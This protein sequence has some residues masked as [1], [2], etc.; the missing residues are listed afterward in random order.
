MNPMNY[1]QLQLRELFHLE[2]LRWFGRKVKA[3]FYALKGGANL[4]FFFQSI[5]YSED[6]DLDVRTI[7]V[8]KLTTT[9]MDILNTRSFT[10]NLRTFSIDRLV[11][12]DLMKAK[13]TATTQRFKIHLI[14][15]AGEDLFTKIEFSRRG[16]KGAVIV[17]PVA[18]SILRFYKLA[19]VLV[20]HY[21]V[22]AA[23]AQK[24]SALATRTVIQAR[25]VFDLFLLSSQYTPQKSREELVTLKETTKAHE[26]M[27]TIEFGQFRDTVVSYLAM[28]DQTSY[29]TPAAWDEIRL[30]ASSFLE[31]LRD[32]R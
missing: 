2:F 30:K 28:E 9:V 26:N 1:N 22:D 23:I 27:F 19:P 7:P 21:D 4:R 14:T 24:I 13:Q 8:E 17:Q 12:P 10:E 18:N 6:M 31:E 15:L 29:G 16:F 11:A 32:Q 3:E 25:D 20:A 5:R